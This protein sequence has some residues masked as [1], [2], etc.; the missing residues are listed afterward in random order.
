M[1]TAAT[2]ATRSRRGDRS[3]CAISRSVTGSKSPSTPM[4]MIGIA[5]ESNLN[6]VGGSASSGMRPRTRSR[7][8]R[9][10][11]AASLRSVPHSE[12]Q[13]DVGAAFRRGRVD[14]VETGDGAD[15]LLDRTR[16]QL[17][18][19]ERPDAGIVDAH[20]DGGHLRVGHQVH[21]QPRQR[22]AAQQ[23]DDHGDHEHRHRTFDGDSRNTHKRVSKR[24]RFTVGRLGRW[25]I[26]RGATRRWG[27]CGPARRRRRVPAAGRSCRPG[28]GPGSSRRR[29]RRRG[30]DRHGPGRDRRHR[31]AGTGL[32]GDQQ[33][34]VVAH[35]APRRSSRT[36]RRP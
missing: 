14:A 6:T 5:V 19:L 1:V 32:A 3:F 36:G 17:L 28:A 7:R 30:L 4:P 29:V 22:D 27:A 21:R 20:R 26:Q 15:R 16:D 13:A 35:G 12:V 11:S 24:M 10:S 9:T 2:P 31:T 33:L 34:I 23:D 8:V 25:W 18:H